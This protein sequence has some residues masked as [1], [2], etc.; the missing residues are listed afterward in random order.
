MVKVGQLVKLLPDLGAGTIVKATSYDLNTDDWKSRVRD[1]HP[2]EIHATVRPGWAVSV[3]WQ[4]DI[5]KLTT[6]IFY[7]GIEDSVLDFGTDNT[8]ALIK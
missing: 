3:R 6:H 5:N 2:D 1:T 7:E 8:I 4:S